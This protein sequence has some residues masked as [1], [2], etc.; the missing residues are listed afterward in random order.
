VPAEEQP[1]AV[2]EVGARLDTAVVVE[3]RVGHVFHQSSC[4]PSY[5]IF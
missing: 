5:C 1:S 2:G 4:N 3:R